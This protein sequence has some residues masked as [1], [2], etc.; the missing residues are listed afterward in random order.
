MGSC[1]F[2]ARSLGG[3]ASCTSTKHPGYSSKSHCATLTNTPAACN[4]CG[5]GC[6]VFTK[7]NK[8]AKK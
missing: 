8:A 1:V 3:Y 7:E 6:P 2:F 5:K 4:K